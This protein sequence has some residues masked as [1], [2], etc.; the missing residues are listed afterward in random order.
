MKKL[1]IIL[2]TFIVASATPCTAQK[3]VS[4]RPVP[5]KRLFVS[6]AVESK[7]IEVIEHLENKRLAWMFANCFPNT[8]DTTIHPNG[9]RTKLANGRRTIQNGLFGELILKI[10]ADGKIEILNSIDIK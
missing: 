6:E 5:E 7:I 8:L 10:I 1:A 9:G 3:Y 2:F 4:R